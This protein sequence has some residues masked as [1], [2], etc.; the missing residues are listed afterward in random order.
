LVRGSTA[1]EA[2]AL[3]DAD[4]PAAIARDSEVSSS[5]AT[6]AATTGNGSHIPAAGITNTNV[7]T[8]AAIAWAKL[9]KTGATAADVG[10]ATSAQGTKA[11]TALQPAAIGSTVQAYDADLQAVAGLTPTQ[12]HLLIRGATAWEARSLVDADI[13]AAIA[14]D[15]EVTSAISTHAAESGNGSHIPAAGITNTNVA[16]GA[17][18]EWAKISKTGAVPADIGAATSAQGALANT[19]LQPSAIGVTVQGYDADLQAIGALTPT[20]NHF[21]VRGASGWEARA[22]T[23]ADIPAAIARDAEV[24][25][26]YQALTGKGAASGYAS[27]DASTLVPQGQLAT[28]YDAIPADM[29]GF[30][31]A[32]AN[33][34]W[35]DRSVL[36][37]PEKT[38][39]PTVGADEVAL[40]A[41][42]ESGYS[43][44][45]YYG[46]NNFVFRIGS[47]LFRLVRNSTGA[48]L[49]KGAIVYINGSHTGTGV[50]PTVARASATYSASTLTV[51]AIGA[52]AYDIPNNTIGVILTEGKLENINTL[53]LEDGTAVDGQVALLGVAA[54]SFRITAVTLPNEIQRIGVI[55]KAHAT[56]GVLLVAPATVITR[57]SGTNKNTWS[58]GDGLASIKTLR[59]LGA[60][61]T[62]ITANPTANRTLALP[63]GDGTLARLSDITGGGGFTPQIHDFT[64]AGTVVV[65]TG[66]TRVQLLV[67]AGASGGSSGRKGAAASN[68]F[69]GGGGAGGSII[70]CEY[71]VADSLIGGVGV[72]LAVTVGAGGLGGAA[73][74]ADNSNGNNGQAGG[75][76]TV[77]VGATTIAIALGGA[78]SSGGTTATGSGGAGGSGQTGVESQVGG[79]G[80]SSSITATAGTGV[81]AIYAGAGG[82]AGSGIDSSDVVRGAG[83]ARWG[84]IYNKTNTN[85]GTNR[86]TPG[87]AGENGTTP[88]VPSVG[89]G[90]TG[91]VASTTGNGG[92]GGSGG[93]GC[94][95]GGGGA[96]TN[97]TGNSGA[98]G[99]GGDGFIRV[100]FS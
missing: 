99:N 4:I 82:G 7:A 91:G 15:S 58:L 95:G 18:I 16:T 37:L 45:N 85:F 40:Q 50:V 75:N 73:A 78:A 55:L 5:I 9:D 62:S 1:W 24:A 29:R 89:A 39:T 35:R 20:Q 28:G 60:F 64:S 49:T 14:R 46:I 51:P 26:A 90:G 93:R 19:A 69:G 76:S 80:G 81:P 52:V 87:T 17:A 100:I 61:T 8:G 92:A 23:D 43:V 86:S 11:D 94:G 97:A 6:H 31:Y 32:D 72:T 21:L 59:F 12:N 84:G 56:Q 71:N 48:T 27:L 77:S 79:G 38:T 54:G 70:D 30:Y 74:T 57:D 68:R 98:G 88:A 41:V 47:D 25:A 63:D 2:R 44:L 13:P 83:I 22:V 36:R 33:R 96:A 67:L 10:A 66:A 34:V 3:L 65:P 53:N 42:D